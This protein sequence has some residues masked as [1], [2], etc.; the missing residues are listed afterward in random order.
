MVMESW[1]IEE[2]SDAEVLGLI[3]QLSEETDTLAVAEYL[4]V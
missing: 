1:L 3:T 2:V 4:F